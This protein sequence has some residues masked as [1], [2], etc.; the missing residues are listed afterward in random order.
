MGGVGRAGERVGLDG[1][2]GGAAAHGD[3]IPMRAASQHTYN[4]AR[5]TSSHQKA[6]YNRV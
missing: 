3:M 4:L 1:W 6:T 5:R 2:R